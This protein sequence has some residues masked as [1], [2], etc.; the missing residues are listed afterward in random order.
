MSSK[1]TS[2]TPANVPRSRSCWTRRQRAEIRRNAAEVQAQADA[3][4]EMYGEDDD[5]WDDYDDR[6]CCHRCG[7]EG[8]I[9]YAEAGPEV[10]GEDCPSEVNHLVTCPEC[11]GEG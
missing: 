6:E 10:W 11:G 3:Y 7:G 2:A 8:F 5:R 1:Y 4:R 9:E